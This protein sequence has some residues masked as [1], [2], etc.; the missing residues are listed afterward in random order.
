MMT[1][2]LRFFFFCLSLLANLRFYTRWWIENL[3]FCIIIISFCSFLL[4]LTHT[5][6]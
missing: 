5:L 6:S 4:S 2:C 1:I 3:W